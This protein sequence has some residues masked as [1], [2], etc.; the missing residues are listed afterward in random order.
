M[1]YKEEIIE[2]VRS[3]LKKINVPERFQNT[4]LNHMFENSKYDMELNVDIRDSGAEF[5]VYEKRVPI[6]KVY[7]EDRHLVVYL[8]VREILMEYYKGLNLE[9]FD[10]MF[11]LLGAPYS[12]YWHSHID[13]WN[14]K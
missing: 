5:E 11:N 2:K 4:Y 10:G 9:E 8:I 6:K 12:E 14:L 13:I 3:L 1:T 7:T